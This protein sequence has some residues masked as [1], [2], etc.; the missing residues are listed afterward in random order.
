MPPPGGMPPGQPQQGPA[1]GQAQ[2]PLVQCIKIL[3]EYAQRLMQ[4][5]PEKGK[6]FVQALATMVDII[7]GGGSDQEPP[8]QPQEPNESAE[9]PQEAKQ[10]K[11]MGKKK[12]GHMP[13]NAKPGAVQVL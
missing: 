3:A 13:M 5:D 9:P 1:D 7:K 10:E 6:Q 4:R 12:M 11:A 8:G 2:N